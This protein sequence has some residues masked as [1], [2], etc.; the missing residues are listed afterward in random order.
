MLRLRRY[1]VFAI[2]AVIAIGLLYHFRG[3]GGI[4]HPLPSADLKDFGDLKNFGGLKPD[5]GL[6]SEG[7]LKSDGGLIITTKSPSIAST[8]SETRPATS[9]AVVKAIETTGAFRSPTVKEDG[10]KTATP[11]SRP[12]KASHV[13]T[14]KPKL[15]HAFDMQEDDAVPEADDEDAV[16][17]IHWKKQKEH[18]PIPTESIIQLPT[19][20]PKAIPKIQHAFSDESNTEKMDREKKLGIIKKTFEFSWAGYKKNAWMHDEL[21]PVSGLFRDPFCGWGATLVD[22][23]DTLWIMG[24]KSEFEEATKAVGKIDFTTSIRND[25]PLFETVIR[26]LGGLIAAYDLGG[27]KY[28]VLLDQAVQLA[29]VLIGAF[30]TPNRMP[31]TFY[32]WKPTF[33]SQPHRA[34]TR[35]VLAELGSLSLEFTRLAQ[36]TKEAKYYDAI[37]RITNEF[38][39]W[40][41]NTRLPGLWPKKVDASGCQKDDTSVMSP[42]GDAMRKGPGVKAMNQKIEKAPKA[43]KPVDYGEAKAAELSGP[44]DD[45]EAAR[46]AGMEKYQIKTGTGK[47]LMNEADDDESP[48]TR[49]TKS[50]LD[51]RQLTE[52]W[53]E[54]TSLLGEADCKPQGLASPPFTSSEE[55]TMGGQAD[56]V[57]EYLPKEY[58][59]LGGLVPQYQ[60]MY[61]LSVE[62]TDKYLLYRPMIPDEKRNI[63]F[64]GQVSTSGRLDDPDDVNLKAEGTHLTCFIGGMIGVGAKIFNREDDLELAKKLT[65][66]CVWAYESTTTGIMPEGFLTL[67]CDDRAK[68]PWN[69]TR[70]WDELDPFRATRHWRDQADPDVVDKKNGAIDQEAKKASGKAGASSQK[71]AQGTVSS[72]SKTVTSEEAV[73][74][75]TKTP[76]VSGSTPSEPAAT[77]SKKAPLAKRQLG[78]IE[79]DAVDS[80]SS[81]SKGAKSGSSGKSTKAKI[82]KEP[83]ESAGGSGKKSLLDP[84]ETDEEKSETSTS[85]T[86]SPTAEATIPVIPSYTPPPIPTQEEYVKARIRDERLPP[87][88]V[89]EAAKLTDHAHRPEAIE[90][91]FIMWRITG[92]NYWRKKG[93]QMFE[94][95]HKAT[96]ADYGASAIMDV[97]S[98][99]PVTLDE[100]E[101]FWLAETLK[102][103]Y[104]LFSDPDLISLDDYVLNTEAHPFKRPK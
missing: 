97:T 72:A 16:S 73:A 50:P 34:N 45:G 31:M 1:R 96:V 27:R 32:L 41:N 55:F 35:V 25:I 4:D 84:S 14:A 6:K 82:G 7:G 94:A 78:D 10:T 93:W 51:K 70:Y 40:Q 56:S 92:D 101:S 23:L 74:T 15:G 77:F 98:E 104:L 83:L 37:A 54:S 28:K 9:S 36:I 13:A 68:C 63:L 75:Q 60:S 26:Y 57:Y 91:V 86:L 5:E 67:P 69:E 11:T 90:S 49:S 43:S 71:E 81:T 64:S 44:L 58:M 33:A 29:E 76:S 48:S 99:T 19:G 12:A 52:D 53:P 38:E 66:G 80:S 79:N 30:D 95:V 85:A 3:L 89:S 8:A 103:F 21:S 20:K 100:M 18:F 47:G 87:G 46:I 42:I 88:V 39:M 2:F 59:L 22:S 65:D 62:A 102:Y 24:L 61:E 17:K